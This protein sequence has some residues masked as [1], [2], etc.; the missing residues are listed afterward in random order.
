MPSIER[1][2][3]D[4]A[5]VAQGVEAHQIRLRGKIAEFEAKLAKGCPG[6]TTISAAEERL[7]VETALKRWKQELYESEHPI[8]QEPQAHGLGLVVSKL[9]EQIANLEAK[10]KGTDGAVS[11]PEALTN[12]QA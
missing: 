3:L 10:L 8:K 2:A 1:P 4:A 9:Q 11:R 7:T 6:G 5:L 12:A